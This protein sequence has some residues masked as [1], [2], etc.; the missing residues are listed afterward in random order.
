MKTGF[1]KTLALSLFVGGALGATPIPKLATHSP[2]ADS[3]ITGDYVEARTC[4]VFAGPCH[5]CGEYDLGGRDVVMA[6][7]FTGGTFEG[8]NLAGIRAAADTSA[9]ANLDNKEAIRKTELVVDPSASDKQV[10]ALTDLLQSKCGTQIGR[11]AAVHRAAV[12][13]AHNGEGYIVSA[14]KF[15]DISV[16]YMPDDSCCTQPNLVW[17][18]PITPLDHRKVGFTNF[19]SYTGSVSE[20]WQREGENGAF[21]GSFTF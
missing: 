9:D 17:Y 1:F 20:P 13:F 21:Y 8:V 6:W 10:A 18:S 16:Q 2:T 19:A 4:S 5:Y 3:K 11:I 15:A 12:T 14:A 7:N